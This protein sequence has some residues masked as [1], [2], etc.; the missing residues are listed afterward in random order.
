MAAVGIGLGLP[1]AMGL[2]RFVQSELFGVTAAD[3]MTLALASLALA[4]VSI[5]AGY[6][7][8]WRATRVD[9]VVALRYE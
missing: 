8:A 2:G 3:A 1:C 6:V 9:P 5:L 7:P 4:A